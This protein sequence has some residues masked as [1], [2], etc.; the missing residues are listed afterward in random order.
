MAVSCFQLSKS[1]LI[2]AAKSRFMGLRLFSCR[3]SVG[4]LHAPSSNESPCCLAW[5]SEGCSQGGGSIHADLAA[6][7]TAVSRADHVVCGTLRDGERASD[8]LCKQGLLSSN[9]EP[10]ARTADSSHLPYRGRTLCV[11]VAGRRTWDQ[12]SAGLSCRYSRGEHS[13][14]WHHRPIAG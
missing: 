2:A 11:P 10:R 3:G 4:V 9:H 6:A 1:V 14:R 5:N 7:L 13:F 12:N 8:R